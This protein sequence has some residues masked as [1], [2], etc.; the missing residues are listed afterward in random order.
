MPARQTA[1]HP[2]QLRFRW[3]RGLVKTRI[4]LLLPRGAMRGSEDT[5]GAGAYV[6]GLAGGRG[7]EPDVSARRPPL[8]LGTRP[9]V[10]GRSKIRTPF[11]GSRSRPS[12]PVT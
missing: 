11:P 9:R 5:A 1:S 3:A 10:G 7:R 4:T 2:C 12:F 6:L 8:L